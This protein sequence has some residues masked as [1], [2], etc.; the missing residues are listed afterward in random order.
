MS[1]FE[2]ARDDSPWTKP[3]RG[4]MGDA[5][6]DL[7]SA[8]DGIVYPGETKTFKTNTKVT[9]PPGW[10]GLVQERSSQGMKGLSTLGNVID[11]TY[12]GELRVNLQNALAADV[13]QR[14]AVWVH[15]G[16]KLAQLVLLPRFIDPDEHLLPVR[17]DKGFGS[18]GAR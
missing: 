2:R 9:L 8:E 5:G 17:G 7:F 14:A 13:R 11:E 15:Q 1:L 12:T 16:D 4:Y 6:Y 10:F 18:T 3:R